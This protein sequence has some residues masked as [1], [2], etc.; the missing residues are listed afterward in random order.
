MNAHT[1]HMSVSDPR[2]DICKAVTPL[3]P[4]A[5]SVALF[6][7]ALELM[8]ELNSNI[9][10]STLN[11]NP[12]HTLVQQWNWL[13]QILQLLLDTAKCNYACTN[14]NVFLQGDDG[15]FYDCDCTLQEAQCP[16]K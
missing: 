1:L 12:L 8:T 9:Y 14:Y 3:C 16:V 7:P 6:S 15:Q 10:Q 13:V 5:S 11:Y 4:A 2:L